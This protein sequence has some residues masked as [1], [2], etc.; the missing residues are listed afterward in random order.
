MKATAFLA[1][2]AAA[3]ALAV[4]VATRADN[5]PGCGADECIGS[6]PVVPSLDPQWSADF[7]PPPVPRIRAA[8]ACIPTDVVFY[9]Q[10]TDWLRVAQKMR[11]NMSLCANYYVSIPPLAADKTKPRGPLQAGL[12]R[13]LGPNFHAMNDINV[14][15]WT[16]WVASDTSRTWYA[17]GVEARH[18]MDDPAVGGFD[19]AAGDIWALNELSSAVRQGSGL[20]RQNMRDFVHGLYDGDGGHPMKGL[21]WVSGISQGTTF[22]DTYKGNVKN[23]LADDSFWLDMSQYVT[24]FS[25]E[26]YGRVDKW[27]VPGTTPQDRLTPTADYL[28]HF[29]NLAAAGAYVLGDTAQY[30]ADADGPT[31]N[32][33][34]PTPGYEW[35]VPAVDYTVAAG[36][37]AAQVYAFRHDQS[38][39]DGDQVFGFAWNPV[40][41]SAPNTIPDF[42][43]KTASILD[44]I[45]AAIHASDAPSPEPGLAACGTDL[46]W[47]TGDV[48]GAT[49]NPAWL[50]FHDWTQPTAQP[51]TAVVQENAAAQLPLSGTDPDPG[52][53]LTFSIVTQPAHGTVTTDGTASATYTPDADYA[54][55]DSF[56]FRTYDGWLNSNVATV[57]L[58]VNAPPVVDAGADVTTQWGVPATLN[59]TATDPDGDSNAL[60]ASWDFGDGS[61]GT[62]LQATHVYAEPGTYAARLTVT[63]ADKGV[64]SDTATV[65]VGPRTSSLTVKTKPTLDVSTAMVAARLGD[66]VD[67]PSAELKGHDVTFAAGGATCTASTNATGDAS[68]TLPAAALALG[69]STVA[70]RF[71]GDK[72]YSES[73]ATGQV[74]IYGTPTG[75]LF[76]VGDR[77]ATGAVTFWSPAWWLA[78][79]LSGGPAPAGFKGFVQPAGTGWTAAPGLDHVPTTVPAW[80]GVIV[81]TAVT[82]DGAVITGDTTKLVVVHVDTYDPAL[83]GQGTVVADAG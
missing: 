14:A 45:A 17:A 37:A 61:T 41:L 54:G 57:T 53:Q 70:V 60:V 82:K 7:V 1:F 64:A 30:F 51:S 46:S 49:F 35:P 13:A 33:A 74:I 21:V 44:R 71:D 26:V 34:W 25:Q 5:P 72:L 6:T 29:G 42:V 20:S 11:A 76:A 2:L 63:D 75:G 8:T 50:T 78:N 9:A 48:A 15:G 56:T 19:P 81:T 65:T 28:E 80:M 3:L 77:S 39:R 31:G 73:T 62:T 66:A 4:P 83:V 24:F 10:Q 67:A 32:A 52:Q 18:R 55:P 69:P 23:W 22:L 79:P 59:G 38:G 36:Y 12:I 27:G 58:K 16:S 43:N 68:C 47:C 40:N